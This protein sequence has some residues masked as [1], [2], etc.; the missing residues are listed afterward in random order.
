MKNYWQNRYDSNSKNFNQSLL[1]QVG[2]TVNG[3]EISEQQIEIMV[4]RIVGALKL[5]AKDSVIDLCCGNGLMT[6][7][8]ES[9][10]G[11]IIGVDFSSGLIEM[12]EK[13]SKAANVSYLHSDVLEL[14]EKYFKGLKKILISE[15]FQH[16]SREQFPVL[17]EKLK[18]L[19]RGSLLF[20]GGI[21]NQERLRDY[22]DTDEKY[23]FYLQR[24]KEGKP[25]IGHW[26]L[27][28]EIERISTLHGFR[29]TYLAQD[30]NL[31]TAHYRFDAVI[32]KL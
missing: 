25:H 31:Y 29:A 21:P 27:M 8:L 12:A 17:L 6:K 18:N 5:D 3:Q 24:E 23:E 32:E 15:A 22:Y 20:L 13:F 1:K 16:F 9:R 28:S 10:V 19:D 7:Q 14:D 2:K 4:E 11:D 26:W 30:P